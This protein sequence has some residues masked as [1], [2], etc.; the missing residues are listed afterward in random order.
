M[1]MDN[2]YF[3]LCSNHSRETR[4]DNFAWD[5]TIDLNRYMRLRGTYEI[6]LLDI[7][8]TGKSDKDLYVYCDVVQPN[9]F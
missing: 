4:P 1:T 7:S 8:F 3:F 2:L 6:A 5:Y 9:L